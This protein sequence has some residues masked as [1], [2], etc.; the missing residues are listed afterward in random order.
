MLPYPVFWQGQQKSGREQWTADDMR[1]VHQWYTTAL[2]LLGP[3]SQLD[4]Y[5]SY[6]RLR[7]IVK[8]VA[9]AMDCCKLLRTVRK[10]AT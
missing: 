4:R 1:R 9:P 6:G 2:A 3:F 8:G 7:A 10:R 5:T